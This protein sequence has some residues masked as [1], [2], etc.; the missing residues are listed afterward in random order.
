MTRLLLFDTAFRLLSAGQL[1]LIALV[2]GRSMAP[3]RI[4]SAT[5]LLLVCVTAYLA[6]VAPVLHLQQS[7]LWPVIQLASQSAPLAL[8]LFAHR[9]FERPIDRRLG[10]AAL[11]V[12]LI[13]WCAFVYAQYV[14]HA[15]PWIADAA[16]H[17]TSLLLAVHAIVIAIAERGDDLLEKRRMFRT[18]FVVLVGLQTLG[19][20]V[21]ESWFGAERG[22][23]W[24]ML[25]Q[26][27]TTLITVMAFG[28]VMLSANAELLFDAQ[29]APGTRSGLSPSE[30]V[31]KLKLDAAMAGGLH[32]SSGLTIGVLAE[33]L[34]VPEHRL[35]AL[36]NQR[37]GYR[38]FSAF[39]NAHR[40]ADARAWLGD[41]AKVDLPVLTIA[42]DL[43][44]G[45]L[46]PFNRAFRDAT[47]QTPSEYRRS[48][49]LDPE[50]G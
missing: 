10:L 13:T 29:A 9:I 40:I 32:R 2:V 19:I 45:S 49:I 37:M 35:R 43:G 39:L 18:G 50:K 41:P 5:V 31:L 34:G 6:N 23:S 26:S 28:A 1:L 7:R 42:M 15:W 44:Y 33:K 30:H 46:A 38:N 12:T 21:A 3:A 24:L 14:S 11:A 16:M 4:R 47:G 48:A 25:V 20:V 22:F 17:L 27:G 36:I 8:W